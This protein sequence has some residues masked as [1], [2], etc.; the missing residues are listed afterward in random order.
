MTT[1]KLSQAE[2]EEQQQLAAANSN[3]C[4][5]DKM[6]FRNIGKIMTKAGYGMN[7][8][9]ARNQVVSGIK[10]ILLF[11]VQDLKS[12]ISLEQVSDMINDQ[13]IQKNLQEV[14]YLAY[15][16]LEKDEMILSK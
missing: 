12:D 2:Q 13:E 4:Q 10:D 15:I 1:V 9:T 14:L 6:D 5:Q 8:A 16:E 3:I 7:H 11:I